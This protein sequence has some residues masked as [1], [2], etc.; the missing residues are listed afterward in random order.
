MMFCAFLPN[1]TTIDG[2][3][4]AN[5]GKINELEKH[6]TNIMKVLLFY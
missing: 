5:V 6:L 2:K 3:T 1:E 4:L